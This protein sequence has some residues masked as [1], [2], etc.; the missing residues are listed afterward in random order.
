MT[1]VRRGCGVMGVLPN[2]TGVRVAEWGNN[3]FCVDG[4]SDEKALHRV[5]KVLGARKVAGT[6]GF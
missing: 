2:R 3:P 4:E 6:T 5:I 1:I